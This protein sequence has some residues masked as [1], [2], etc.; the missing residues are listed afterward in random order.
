ML[1]S[2]NAVIKQKLVDLSASCKQGVNLGVM[3]SACPHHILDLCRPVYY[4]ST[5]F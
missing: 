4:P 1:V 5:I 3:N 2:F